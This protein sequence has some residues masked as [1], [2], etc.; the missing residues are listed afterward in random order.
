MVTDFTLFLYTVDEYKRFTKHLP[1]K[2]T[3]SLSDDYSE[4]DYVGIQV[5]LML[6]RKYYAKSNKEKVYFKHITEDGIKSFIA[7]ASKFQVLDG[8]FDRVKEQQLEHILAD[9]TKL[10]IYATIEDCVYGLYLHADENRINHLRKTDESIRFMCT[11]KYI[12]EIESLVFRL[13]D[14][15][16]DCGVAPLPLPDRDRAPI[17][18][19]GD[20]QNNQQAIS[21]S[22][23]WSNLYGYDATSADMEAIVGTLPAEELKMLELCTTFVEELG[24]PDVKNKVLKKFIHPAARSDWGDFSQAKTLINGIP[25]PGFSTK[26]R[27]NEAKDTAYVRIQ[28]NVSKEFIISSPH[29]LSEVYEFALGKWFGKWMIYSLGGHLDS[30]YETRGRKT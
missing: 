4:D 16:V 15:L 9:G 18:Y 14:L 2:E 5:R 11:R 12:L 27:Y 25:N 6:L 17:I 28:P 3:F 7:F 24:K 30:I 20:P 19:L 10:D 23:Y 26:V 29:V 8:E 13:Y 21:A 1:V 22:P